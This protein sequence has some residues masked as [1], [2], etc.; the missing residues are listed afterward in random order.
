[1]MVIEKKELI[2]Q[3]QLFLYELEKKEVL[4]ESL[5]WYLINNLKKYVEKLNI[6]ETSSQIK[7]ATEK[8]DTFCIES[9]DWDTPLFKRCS[10]ITELGL[11]LARSDFNIL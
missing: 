2:D 6:A 8:F 3:V 11:K 5:E 4:K 10:K 1:M 7:L 9:M